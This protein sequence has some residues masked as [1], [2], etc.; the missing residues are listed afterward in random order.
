MDTLATD[1]RVLSAKVDVPVG[2]TATWSTEG[3]LADWA[4]PYQARRSAPGGGCRPGRVYVSVYTHNNKPS[5]WFR[6]G[7]QVSRCASVVTERVS[8]PRALTQEGVVGANL[9]S[10]LT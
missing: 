8:S 9:S 1:A 3:C 6:A 10:T 7:K 2:G 5:I 4:G